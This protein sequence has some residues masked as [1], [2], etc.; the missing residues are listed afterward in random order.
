MSMKVSSDTVILGIETSCDETAAA[1][2]R[3]GTDIQSSIVSSQ[4]DI[5]ARYGGVVPEIASRAHNDLIIPVVAQALVEAGV[6]GNDIDAVAATTGPGL[7]GALL[8]GV[9]AAKAFALS[10]GVPFVAVNH[11]EAHL[12][13]AL[14]EEPDLEFPLVVLLVSGGHTMLVLMEGHGQY[15]LLGQ[16]LDDAAGE[17]FDK[18][19]RFLGLGYPGGPAIDA[20]ALHGDPEAIKFPRS[21]MDG[22]FDFSFSGLKTSVVNYVRKNPDASTA[23]ISASFQAAVVDVLVAKARQAAK[24]TGA[25]AL[26]LGGGVA[27]NSLLR[28]RFLGACVDDG[29]QG[30]LPSRAMCT[31]NAAMI[32]A[33]GWYLLDRNGP[34]GLDTGA[35]PNLKLIPNI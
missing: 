21:L 29:V 34:S 3:G 35:T 10:W 27:A 17:A 18:V 6:D 26:A 7:I 13:A 14:L 5:H 4:V 1:V 8:V 20:E 31:D 23:D 32:A 25:K 28:E 16:T 15:R 2:V 11:L 9:S 22:S 24:E 30:F 12:Y 19:A 33:A